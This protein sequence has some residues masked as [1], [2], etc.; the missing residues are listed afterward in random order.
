MFYTQL[1]LDV[2]AGRDPEAPGQGDPEGGGSQEIRA[3][4]RGGRDPLRH[5]LKENDKRAHDAVK[6]A[7]AATKKKND[8][9]QEIKRLNQ[10]L[11]AVSSEMSK[12][13]EAL[14]DCLKYR[15]FL[16]GLTPDTHFEENKKFKKKGSRR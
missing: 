6:E 10:Q 9:V 8:K 3:E 11:Q 12:Q 13:R 5:F 16:D 1:S 2:K 15:E 14:D 4:A 7:E